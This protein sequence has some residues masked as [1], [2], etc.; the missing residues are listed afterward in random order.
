MLLLLSFSVLCFLFPAIHLVFAFLF[1][2]FFSHPS[3]LTH[4]P[5]STSSFL[6]SPFSHFSFLS[7]SISP[8]LS[9]MFQVVIRAATVAVLRPV[10]PRW[11]AP[12]CW[13][14]NSS[15][16]R[17]NREGEG[18]VQFFLKKSSGSLETS[19]LS[20]PINPSPPFPSVLSF[21]HSFKLSQYLSLLLIHKHCHDFH[22]FMLHSSGCESFYELLFSN[23]QLSQG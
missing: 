10:C 13:W 7:L 4:P 12:F 19:T 16:Y 9:G 17:G 14:T 20:R 11:H 6:P 5:P 8:P 22:S 21:W 23:K 2:P 3:S 15:T 18:S 1:P